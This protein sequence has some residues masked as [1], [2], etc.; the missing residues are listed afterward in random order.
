MEGGAGA[1]HGQHAGDVD[2]QLGRGRRIGAGGDQEGPADQPSEEGA[3]MQPA[4]Q[5]RTLTAVVGAAPLLTLGQDRQG[6]LS[7]EAVRQLHLTSRNAEQEEDGVEVGHAEGRIRRLAHDRLGIEGNAQAC[8]GQHVD[9][10][11]AVAHRDGARQRHARRLREC[12]QRRG[13]PGPVDNRAVEV[14]RDD[15]LVHGEHIRRHMVDAQLVDQR[16]R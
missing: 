12:G 5:Q 6:T 2:R 16:R 3:G 1:E 10:V 11:G 9:V 8:C 4:P 7:F 14:T 13:L 15:T